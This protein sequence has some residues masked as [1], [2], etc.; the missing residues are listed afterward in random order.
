MNST[1]YKLIRRCSL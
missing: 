1:D